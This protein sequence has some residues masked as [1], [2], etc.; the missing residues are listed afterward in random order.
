MSNL[1]CE[2]CPD[3]NITRNIKPGKAK[4]KCPLARMQ[5]QRKVLHHI[6]QSQ[7]YR[8]KMEGKDDEINI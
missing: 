3:I 4:F 5:A 7:K 1:N 2:T 6:V 8:I